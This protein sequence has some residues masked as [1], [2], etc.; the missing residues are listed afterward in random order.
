MALKRR[1]RRFAPYNSKQ[2][3]AYRNTAEGQDREYRPGGRESS[4][5]RS[6][7]P[8]KARDSQ[9]QY[10]ANQAEAGFLRKEKPP[11]DKYAK[12]ALE[13]RLKEL[14]SRTPITD[15]ENR[16]KQANAEVRRASAATAVDNKRMI[17][18]SERKYGGSNKSTP[19]HKVS[20]PSRSKMN[21]ISQ[22]FYNQAMKSRAETTAT[23][24][25]QLKGKRPIKPG[26][27]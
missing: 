27:R 6:Q 16:M 14:S 17:A 15:S 20:P 22:N 25:R 13:R 3:I 7:V 23:K 2:A 24:V 11:T 5:Y 8:Q 26:E 4:L 18:E 12:Q 1:R 10:E 19:S 21:Q 9:D